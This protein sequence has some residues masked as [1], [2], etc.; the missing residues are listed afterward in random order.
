MHLLSSFEETSTGNRSDFDLGDDCGKV[1]LADGYL[2]FDLTDLPISSAEA[3]CKV[4]EGAH[5]SE[6]STT[7]CSAWLQQEY[8]WDPEKYQVPQTCVGTCEVAP[9]PP[10]PPPPPANGCDDVDTDKCEVFNHHYHACSHNAFNV[11]GFD[12]LEACCACGGGTPTA[13]DYSTWPPII[14]NTCPECP[15][16]T[17][18]DLVD[19]ASWEQDWDDTTAN[20]C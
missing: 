11:S 10:A 20:T 8:S 18:Q 12:P 17:C 2:Y 6:S 1:Q 9:A 4:V 5:P 13:V 3:A 19:A 16:G 7:D 15:D 14:G